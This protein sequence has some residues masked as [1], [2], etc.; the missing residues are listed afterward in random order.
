MSHLFFMFIFLTTI[1]AAWMNV[2]TVSAIAAMQSTI[3]A[4]DIIKVNRMVDQ[5]HTYMVTTGKAPASLDDMITGGYWTAASN[6]NGLGGTYTLTVD[7]VRRQVL[8]QTTIADDQSRASYLASNQHLWKP[9][10]MGNGVV[11]A[12]ATLASDVP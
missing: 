3:I 8:I 10:D 12:Q 1:G 11:Q 5:V 2:G 6:N 4:N 7:T 9:T